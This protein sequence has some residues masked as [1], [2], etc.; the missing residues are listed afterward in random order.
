MTSIEL[1]EQEAETLL[2]NADVIRDPLH[3]DISI[4]AL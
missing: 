1:S 4:T 2:Q 3:G